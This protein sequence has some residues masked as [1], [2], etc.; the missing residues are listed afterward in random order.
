MSG[1]PAAV[2]AVRLAV[3]ESLADLAGGSSVVVAVS[4]GADSMALAAALLHESRRS[5]LQLTAVVVDHGLQTGSA[6]VAN[7]T[8]AFLAELGYQRVQVKA[9]AVGTAG[10]PEAAARLARYR[11]ID[12]VA[13]EVSAVA[14]LL[15]HTR[16]DQAESVLLGLARGSGAGSIKGMSPRDGRYRRPLLGVDRTTTRQA[17]SDE[18]LPVWDDPHNDDPAFTRVRV[19]QSVLP[20]LEAELGPGVVA[21]LAR[22]ASMLQADDAALHAWA[23]EVSMKAR[24]DDNAEGGTSVVLDVDVLAGV[25]DAVRVRVIRSA[26]LDAGV[27]GGALRSSHLADVDALV[28]SWKGQGEVHL[29]GRFGASRS[30][31]RLLIARADR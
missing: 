14:V 29:P 9:V 24:L 13:D 31:G 18:S 3:R 15:G 2:A 30:Y 17:C 23:D 25:P 16:G 10:G 8:V 4:G 5:S 20:V 1:P 7:S 28:S 6:D 19:R 27:P 12:E 21:A 26:L 11:A 22:T